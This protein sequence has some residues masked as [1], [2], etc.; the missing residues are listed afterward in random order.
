MAEMSGG[1]VFIC[2][3]PKGARALVLGD[4]PDDAEERAYSFANSLIH[5]P[6]LMKAG[7][8]LISI[9][10]TVNDFHSIRQSMRTAR[11]ARHL[12]NAER[13]VDHIIIGIN[14]QKGSDNPLPEK[15]LSPLYERLQYAQTGSVE[16]IL[17]EY[18][19]SMD[20]ALALGYLRVAAL[21]AARRIIQEAGGN[22]KDTLD[23]QQITE[24]LHTEGEEGLRRLAAL[25]RS[26]WN[27]G[28]RTDPATAIPPSAMP[29]LILPSTIQIRI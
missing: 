3:A 16:M 1:G 11:H 5:L 12:Q 18:S 17:T 7:H 23:E 25:L 13:P 29:V 8:L 20:P 22:P 2:S 24:A 27:T 4:R 15:E 14:E 19:E 6:E 21:L 26:Q 28:I 10:E 9:G